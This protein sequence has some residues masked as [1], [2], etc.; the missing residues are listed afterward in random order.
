MEHGGCRGVG[1]A[2]PLPGYSPESFAQVEA[3]L[4]SLVL[5]AP[6]PR[7]LGA[8]LALADELVATASAR[9]AVQTAFLDWLSRTLR[10]PVDRL[11]A[12]E[13]GT[14]PHAIDLAALEQDTLYRT[15]KIKIAG[16]ADLD[17]VDQVRRGH[18]GVA[19]RLDANQSLREPLAALH[20]VAPLDIEFVEE[21]APVEVMIGLLTGSASP[22]GLALDESL[23]RPDCSEALR[24]WLK[25]Y[26]VLVLKPAVLGFTR[27]VELVRIAAETSASVVVSHLFDG[28]FALASAAAFARALPDGVSATLAHG[29]APHAALSAFCEVPALGIDGARWPA[30]A[31]LGLCRELVASHA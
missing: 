23:R 27:C 16:V 3:E 25:Y 28:P 12:Q 10:I 15:W 5:P 11:W 7:S 29:L 20:R 9:F 21:P 2:C 6:G 4:T 24:V 1:E 8:A 18:R 31:G 14:Q 13:L 19:L 26:R 30:A 22:V 17:R